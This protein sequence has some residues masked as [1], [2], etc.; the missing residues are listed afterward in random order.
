MTEQ[1]FTPENFDKLKLTC[2]QIIMLADE[3]L[4]GNLMAVQLIMLGNKIGEF[5]DNPI[6]ATS[7]VVKK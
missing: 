3:N 6:V 5:I 2:Q 4:D 1:P 7:G